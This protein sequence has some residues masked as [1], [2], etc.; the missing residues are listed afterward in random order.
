MYGIINLRHNF[1]IPN[2]KVYQ[3]EMLDIPFIIIKYMQESLTWN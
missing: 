3:V 1:I 2:L